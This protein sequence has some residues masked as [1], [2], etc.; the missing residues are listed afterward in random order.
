MGASLEGGEASEGAVAREEDMAV[1]AFAVLEIAADVVAGPPGI[2]ADGEFIEAEFGIDPGHV[3]AAV[4]FGVVEEVDDASL[5]DGLGV[6]DFGVLVGG[7]A[8]GAEGEG[9]VVDGF[10]C[11]FD[12]AAGAGGEGESEEEE[13]GER[14]HG[15]SQV[16]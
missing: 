8:A 16:G 11:E 14:T 9:V 5:L 10:A 1:E 2:E 13:G 6:L 3:D 7:P 12:E 4:E 15:D